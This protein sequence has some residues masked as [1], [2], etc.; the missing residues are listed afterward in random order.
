MEVYI[1]RPLLPDARLRDFEYSAVPAMNATIAW[2]GAVAA[3][4]PRIRLTRSFD[5]R[6]HSYLGYLLRIEGSIGGASADFRVGVG[7]VA[8]AKYQFR[9]G[10]HVE[11]LGH[12]VSDPRLETAEIY[13]VSKLRVLRRG[14]GVATTAP[15]N[16]VPPP[17]EVY[18]A[19][20]HRRLAVTTYDSKCHSCIWGC[21][22]PVEMIVD[23]WNPDRR[24][25]RTETF[26]YGPLSCSAYKPGPTRK[27]PG[28]HGMSYEEED[29]IDQDATA[30]RTPDE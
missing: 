1:K 6:S 28:R 9:T 2:S 19:R 26:C 4:Q 17:L 27:V 22:M 11:G 23:H 18:R 5:E 20:G 10:D 25:Y 12:R 15:W 30:H 21:V 16:G 8:H 13:K 14:E 7:P 24:R 3:V 29:W